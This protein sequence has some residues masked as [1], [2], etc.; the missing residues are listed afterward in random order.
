MRK[1]RSLEKAQLFIKTLYPLITKI[2]NPFRDQL[3]RSSLSIALNLAEGF[4]KIGAERKRFYRIAYGSAK[5]TKC[6]M[7][8]LGLELNDIDQICAMTYKLEKNSK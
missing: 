1:F 6:C 7:E 3:K 8:I 5:E 4:A 2:E